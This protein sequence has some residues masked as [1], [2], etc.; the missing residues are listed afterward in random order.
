MMGLG[1]SAQPT[2]AKITPS[3]TGKIFI[4]ITGVIAVDTAGGAWAAS[5]RWGT[6]TAPNNGA[7]ASGSVLGPQAALTGNN[8]NAWTPFSLCG[9]LTGKAIGTPLWIDMS[10]DVGNAGATATA[11]GVAVTAVELP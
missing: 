4:Q 5:L 2:P 9:L 6:G 7:V 3:A 8:A 11:T 10:L 1:S